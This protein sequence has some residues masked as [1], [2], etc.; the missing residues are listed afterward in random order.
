MRKD[1]NLLKVPAR[2]ETLAC[3]IEPHTHIGVLML[4]MRLC[5]EED[6]TMN[7]SPYTDSLHCHFVVIRGF[8]EHQEEEFGTADDHREATGY[9]ALMCRATTT[10]YEH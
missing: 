4:V 6:Q 10:I 9:T 8:T 2:T 7:S 1:W 3:A 5:S